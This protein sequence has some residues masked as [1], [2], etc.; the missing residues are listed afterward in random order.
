[1]KL[2]KIFSISTL[3]LLSISCTKT[4]NIATG[5][6]SESSMINSGSVSIKM[7]TKPDTAT[8][9][10]NSQKPEDFIPKGFVLFE[11]TFGDL[12][13]DGKDDCVLIIKDTQK[14]NIFIHDSRGD[15]DRNRR[16]L[17]VLFKTDQGYEVAAKNYRC[18]SSENEDGGNY[19]APDLGVYVEKGQLHINYA[20]GRY[21]Y[22][23][24]RFRYQSGTFKLIGYD[25]ASHHGPT[26]LS[27]TSINYLTRQKIVRT[28]INENTYDGEEIFETTRSKLRAKPLVVLD[29]IPDFDELDSEDFND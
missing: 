5:T 17:I 12:N 25:R 29:Q 14:E 3:L 10:T 4:E 6:T 13:K 24:Y 9:S 28:N 22:W 7:E 23:N 2:S 27:E 16:G 8:L 18:F 19:Y 21:G 11:K 26:V 1:M 15:L 20:H